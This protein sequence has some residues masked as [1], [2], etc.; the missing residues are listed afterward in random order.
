MSWDDYGYGQSSREDVHYARRAEDREAKHR[1]R[2]QDDA[3]RQYARARA[4][5]AALARKKEQ[6]Q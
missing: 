5:R 6:D 3:D 4:L 1:D 2:Q